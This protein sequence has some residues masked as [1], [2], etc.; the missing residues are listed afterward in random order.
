MKKFV[1][2]LL[3]V[4]FVPEIDRAN[5]YQTVVFNP[6]NERIIKIN[7]FSYEILKTI[8]ENEAISLEDL[9]SVVGKKRAL[10][11]WQVEAKVVNFLNQMLKENVIFEKE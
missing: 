5:N 10:S 7:R 2:N 6:Q 9:C 11:G 4:L 1:V 8:D 3:A